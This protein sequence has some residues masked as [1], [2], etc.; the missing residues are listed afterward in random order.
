MTPHLVKW[1]EQY[2]NQGLRIIDVDN[3]S[4][5]PLE[6]LQARVS[7]ENTPYPVYHDENGRLANAYGV[8][9]YPAA[10]LIDRRGKVIWEGHPRGGRELE[11]EIEAALAQRD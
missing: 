2:E 4:F 11:Q 9:S 3:G 7:T 10:Y 5:D 8:H 1:F 6:D